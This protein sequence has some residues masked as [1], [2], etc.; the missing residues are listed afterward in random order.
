[1]AK[2][3][4]NGLIVDN[5]IDE[6]LKPQGNNSYSSLKFLFDDRQYY[7]NYVV[8]YINDKVINSP[9]YADLLNQNVLFGL[10]D[11]KL[12]IVYRKD[13]KQFLKK[14]PSADEKDRYVFNFVADAFNEMNEYIS[15]AA[16]IGKMPRDSVYFDLK[17]HND[18]TTLDEYL[19]KNQNDL[20]DSFLYYLEINQKSSSKIKDA[21]SFIDQF[22]IYLTNKIKENKVVTKTTNILESNFY[23]SF[24]G[25]TIDISKDEAGNDTKKFDK[26]LTD[27]G[28]AVFADACKRFGFFIDGRIPWRLMPNLESPAMNSQFGNHNG[29]MMKNGIYN[30]DYLFSRFFSISAYDELE[31]IKSFFYDTY[32]ALIK[33]Y[34]FCDEDI[35]NLSSCD[36]KNINYK[37]RPD[38]S[39][40]AFNNIYSDTYWMRL[41]VYFR[42]YE[43]KR[44]LKQQEFENIVREANYF[45]QSNLTSRALEYVN[46][47]FKKFDYVYYFSSLQTSKERVQSNMQAAIKNNI[48]F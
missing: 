33:D 13:E 28:F 17:C 5:G 41:Y 11:K 42:N 24:N 44:N 38:I 7:S 26:Y 40:Q 23:Y 22:T 46:N 21:K 27:S 47:Y 37:V 31:Y 32:K 20:S 1:M 48:T 34:P 4:D 9:L 8:P 18:P 12:N 35:G 29:Y 36:L 43:E 3:R 15:K 6:N 2:I 19:K 25:L 39:K 45:V 30:A 14:I 10:M 16:V